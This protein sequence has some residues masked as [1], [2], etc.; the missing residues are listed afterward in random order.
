MNTSGEGKYK[1]FLE[2]REL[3]RNIVYILGGGERSHIGG[4]AICEPGKKPNTIRLEGHYD[5]V[6]LKPIAKEACKKYKTTIVVLGGVHIDNASKREIDILV[7]NC[8]ELI[9]YI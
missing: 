9:K 4:I 2:K 5:D 3:D 7:K 8:K 6:V 1:V